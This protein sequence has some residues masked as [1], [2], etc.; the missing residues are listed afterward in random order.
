MN[1]LLST[2]YP[3]ATLHTPDAAGDENTCADLSDN[4][5][6]RVFDFGKDRV[7]YHGFM[8]DLLEGRVSGY[9]LDTDERFSPSCGSE[10]HFVKMTRV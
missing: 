6:V 7:L 1:K 10:I 3:K 4:T 8:Y 5:V 2:F 9:A